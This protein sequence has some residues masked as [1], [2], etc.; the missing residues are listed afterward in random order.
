MLVCQ[1]A[2]ALLADFEWRLA[3]DL[4]RSRLQ[5]NDSLSSVLPSESPIRTESLLP[6]AGLDVLE[7]VAIRDVAPERH[8]QVLLCQI[9]RL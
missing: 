8:L 3:Q 4:G 5:Q 2:E 6:L 7:V 9:E 1:Q